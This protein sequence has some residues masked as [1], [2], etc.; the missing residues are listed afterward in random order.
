MKK[1]GK[2]ATQETA[3]EPT[4]AAAFFCLPPAV[5]VA[6]GPTTVTVPIT[7]IPVPLGARDRMSPPTVTLPPAVSVWPAITTALIGVCGGAAV[8]VLKVVAPAPFTITAPEFNETTCP[9]TV[10]AMPL[11]KVCVPITSCDCAFSVNVDWP[12]TT[13]GMLVG[14]GEGSV[15]TS[16]LAVIAEPGNKV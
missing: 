13:I 8:I 4:L 12:T 11:L 9:S 1:T 6:S 2:P 10:M 15:M 7:T 16:P 5:A 3:D 14:D